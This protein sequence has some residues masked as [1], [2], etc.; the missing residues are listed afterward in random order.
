MKTHLKIE[1]LAGV[2]G[3]PSGDVLIGFDKEA[4]RSYGLEQSAN[5]AVSE[6]AVSAYRSGLNELIKNHSQRLTGTMVVHWFKEIIAV[7]DDPL[8][9]L[10]ES[11]EQ[12]EM[13]SQHAAKKLLQSIRTG[14]RPDLAQ[15]YFYALTLSGAGGRVMVR[16]WMEGPFDELVRNINQW[17]D[18][19]KIVRR[20]GSQS[21]GNPKFMA[22]LGS[23]VRDLKDLPAPLVTKMWRVAVCNEAIP[24]SVLAQT[25]AR[26]KIE[27]LSEEQTINSSGIGLIK[28]YQIR[29]YRKEGNNTMADNLKPVLNEDFPS[30]AYHCGRLMAVLA[31]LQ[32]A[33]LGDVGAGVVQRYYAAASTTPALVLGRLTRTSQFHL[34]KLEPGLAYWYE[35]KIAGIWSRLN[36]APPR[37]LSLEDQSLF[38]MGYYQQLASMKVR[39]SE[40]TKEEKEATNG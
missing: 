32:R 4:Y 14:E 25:L 28:A 5:A 31:E 34:N 8:V 1:R 27:I 33:A 40:N 20:D 29:K 39:K 26:R 12:Q 17:F 6:E 24:F 36:E 7:T 9:W 19:L 23:L 13:N 10:V 21:A 37:T 38:A 22:V 15:N 16:D 11:P 3:Q 30:P 2:G 35:G 18:D